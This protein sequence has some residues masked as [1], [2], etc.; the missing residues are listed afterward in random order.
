MYTFLMFL[1]LIALHGIL[2]K[3]LLIRQLLNST[4]THE[5]TR[6][7]QTSVKLLIKV[8]DETTLFFSG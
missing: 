8:T 6:R 5:S 3:C 4:F 7:P 2:Y 1:L